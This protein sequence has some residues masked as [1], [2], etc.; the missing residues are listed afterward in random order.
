MERTIRRLENFTQL[1]IPSLEQRI[2]AESSNGNVN[3]KGRDGALCVW[4]VD[5]VQERFQNM[6]PGDF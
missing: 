1:K 4:E 5:V 6:S 3:R 2:R